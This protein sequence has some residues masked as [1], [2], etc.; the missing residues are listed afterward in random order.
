MYYTKLDSFTY[1]FIKF[2]EYKKEKKRKTKW[3]AD[4]VNICI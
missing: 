2:H 3:V 4:G 1:D